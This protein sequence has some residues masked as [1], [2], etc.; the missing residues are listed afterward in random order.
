VTDRSSESGG[1]AIR[2]PL[3]QSLAKVSGGARLF[4]YE[5]SAS[6]GESFDV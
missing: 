2:P 4:L 3:Q 6:S 1:I 5:F